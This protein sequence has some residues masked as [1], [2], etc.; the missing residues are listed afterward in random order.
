VIRR[1]GWLTAALAVLVS[2]GSSERKPTPLVVW[3]SDM[4][5]RYQNVH[6]SREG[7]PVTDAVVRV[8]GTALPWDGDVYRAALPATLAAGEILSL[9]VTAGDATVT[10]RAT[11]P[12]TPSITAPAS[13]AALPA[14]GDVQV[15]WTC[16][17]DPDRFEVSLSWTCG[18]GC[19]GSASHVASGAVRTLAVPVGAISAGS[20]VQLSVYAYRDGVLGGDYAPNESYPGM[21]VRAPSDPL[22]VT[23]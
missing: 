5:P 15:T 12:A 23:K 7:T 21:N 4:G 6:V 17:A 19:S 2:C 22:T 20:Q 13:G 16:A 3:G 1:L 18:I 8:N 11:V 14:T 10:G 9:E